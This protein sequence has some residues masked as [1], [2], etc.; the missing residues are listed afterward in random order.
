MDWINQNIEPYVRALNTLAEIE[1]KE[2]YTGTREFL[3]TT[4]I[5]VFI[6]VLTNISAEYL[7]IGRIN[8]GFIFLILSLFISLFSFYLWKRYLIRDLQKAIEKLFYKS[9]KSLKEKFEKDFNIS[10]SERGSR[11]GEKVLAISSIKSSPSGRNVGIIIGVIALVG[12][13]VFAIPIIPVSYQEPYQIQVPYDVQVPYNRTE[14][15]AISLD[16]GTYDWTLRPNDYRYQAE[17]VPEDRDIEISVKTKT[18]INPLHIYIF[19]EIEYNKWLKN[20]DSGYNLSLGLVPGD[21]YFCELKGLKDCM[22]RKYRTSWSGIYYLVIYNPQSEE[23]GIDAHCFLLRWEEEVTEYRTETN[24]KTETHY[25]TIKK[26]VT[27][28]AYITKAY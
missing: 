19:T 28:W 17:Y 23:V 7:I 1:T 21:S 25:K 24:Y 27:L 5:G 22:S 18:K 8:V 20:P 15:I 4:L 6:G 3:A 16:C 12:F 14:D 13:L 9:E 11:G 10:S 26:T 2:I